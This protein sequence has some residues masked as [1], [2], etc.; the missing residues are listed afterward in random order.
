M[1]VPI[2]K[3]ASSR[4]LLRAATA[5]LHADIDARFSG[6]FS[7]SA[8][9]YAGFLAAL[10]SALVPLERALEEAGVESILPDWPERRRADLVLADLEALGSDTPPAASAPAMQGEARQFG[11]AY[12]LEGSRLGGKLLLRRA[13]ANPDARVRAATRY[14]SHGADRDFWPSFVTRL[15]ASS[16][17]TRAPGEAIAGARMA[18]ALFREPASG[19]GRG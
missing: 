2:S 14:L 9:A 19:A 1:S 16:A 17:V 4:H 15:D 8:D 18:F 6:N 13:L 12:V 7:G 5:D 10:A 11:V 3:P